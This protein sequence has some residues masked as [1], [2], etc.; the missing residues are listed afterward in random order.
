LGQLA[1]GSDSQT[2]RGYWAIAAAKIAFNTLESL[3]SDLVAINPEVQFNFSETVEL[4]YRDLV[5]LL[6][7]SEL[8]QENLKEAC[9]VIESLQ[10]AE[11]ENFF[12]EACLNTKSV[13]LEQVDETAAVIYLIIL[14]D[15][16]EVILSLPD[17]TIRNY[18]TPVSSKVVE[19]TLKQLYSF[20]HLAFSGSER[21][22]LQEQVYDWLIRLAEAA[23]ASQGIKTLVFVQDGFLQADGCPLRRSKVPSREI[24]HRP[25]SRVAIAGTAAVG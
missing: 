2:A 9:Q 18:A 14:P 5:S 21:L 8:D 16:L 4:V 3:R 23:L 22:R 1:T 19:S 20:L 13:L 17:G 11:L 15:R 10:L 6:L 12:Q 7:Q 24:Q 25:Q